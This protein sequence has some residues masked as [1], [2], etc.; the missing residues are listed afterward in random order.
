VSYKN[1][2]Q[3][4]FHDNIIE[5]KNAME[6]NF[7]NLEFHSMLLRTKGKSDS[8]SEEYFNTPAN[9]NDAYLY[10][11][12]LINSS[13]YFKDSKPLLYSVSFHIH[14]DSIDYNHTSVTINTINPK[15]I[16]GTKFGLSDNLK[17]RTA[18]FR[19]VEPSTV[20]EYEI[21]LKIGSAIRETEM[22]KLII[23]EKQ[24]L[25]KKK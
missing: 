3:Y 16:V 10:S 17:I 2:T 6:S 13:I 21:L 20:E 8:F 9:K 11:F 12:D 14:L 19:E 25:S 1:P 7:N 4:T 23:P 22:P 24:T 5:V 18:D 15:V